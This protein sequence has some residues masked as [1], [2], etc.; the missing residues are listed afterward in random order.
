MNTMIEPNWKCNG[1]KAPLHIRL[2]LP[3]DHQ[4]T[5]LDNGLVSW[6]RFT[7]PCDTE[8]LPI[9]IVGGIVVVVV[10]LLL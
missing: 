8:L 2:V 4:W 9:K 5:A 1:A 6:H 3:W 10:V 7:V